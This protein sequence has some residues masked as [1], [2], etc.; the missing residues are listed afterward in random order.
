MIV[1]MCA[2]IKY[3]HTHI[4]MYVLAQCTITCHRTKSPNYLHRTKSTNNRATK[5]ILTINTEIRHQKSYQKILAAKHG[6][7]P[8]YLNMEK[9]FQF[10]S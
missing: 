10:L 9:Q 8:R 5:P 6:C 1:S 3:T 7:P 2:Y 4:Y